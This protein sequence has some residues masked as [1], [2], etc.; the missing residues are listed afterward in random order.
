MWIPSPDE[1]MN[2][3]RLRHQYIGIKGVSPHQSS[4][5]PDPTAVVSKGTNTNGNPKEQDSEIAPR[6]LG[7]DTLL[8]KLKESVVRDVWRWSRRT[9]LILLFL[10]Q[11][12]YKLDL[13]EDFLASESEQLMWVKYKD[14]LGGGTC[15]LFL[16]LPWRSSILLPITLFVVRITCST[17]EK[18]RFLWLIPGSDESESLVSGAQKSSFWKFR[19]DFFFL[20][21]R[22]WGLLPYIHIIVGYSS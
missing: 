12:K 8:S 22:D 15:I 17:C 16:F 6:H 11:H 9:I 7:C 18:G 2:A 5:F 21:F 4:Q 20:L 14:F 3:F 10:T 13:G 1:T 19:L